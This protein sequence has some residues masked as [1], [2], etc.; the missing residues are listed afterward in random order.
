MK[1]PRNRMQTD[2]STRTAAPAAP[3]VQPPAEAP[4]APAPAPAPASPPP[5]PV[6][7][8]WQGVDVTFNPGH[9]PECGCSDNSIYKTYAKGER[10]PSI[11][12]R[13]H[14]CANC[15][16]LFRSCQELSPMDMRLHADAMKAKAAEA[17][18]ATS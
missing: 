2:R 13:L 3:P 10:F 17:S 7:R 16:L 1:T 14:Q 8:M 15:G 18:K 4:T 11:Q 12:N 5:D 9:C 6:R